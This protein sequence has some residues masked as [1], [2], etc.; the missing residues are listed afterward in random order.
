MRKDSPLAA[1]IAAALVLVIAGALALPRQAW[2]SGGAV[3]RI[4][5]TLLNTAVEQGQVAVGALRTGLL[6]SPAL[7]RDRALEQ[8]EPER[9]A[10]VCQG[11][12]SRSCP[13]SECARFRILRRIPV[14]VPTSG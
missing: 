7:L 13:Q 3:L 10:R 12:R 2:S 11:E 9:P 14:L 8:S 5:P 1:C 6:A 4:A